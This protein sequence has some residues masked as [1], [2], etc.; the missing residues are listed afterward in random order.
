MTGG[1]F[2]W[3]VDPCDRHV[4]WDNETDMPVCQD[5]GMVS[6]PAPAGPTRGHGRRGE[7]RRGATDLQRVTGETSADALTQGPAPR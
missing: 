6:L 3:I 4:L 7:R 2:E 5:S 1:R